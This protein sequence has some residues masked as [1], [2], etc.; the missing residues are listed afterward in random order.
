MTFRIKLL[1]S[2]A[3]SSWREMG[4]DHMVTRSWLRHGAALTIP[5]AL[6][7]CGGG[8]GGV[9]S[10]PAP[11]VATIPTPVPVPAPPPPPPPPTPTAS[12]NDT[13][14]YRATVGAVSMNALAAYNQGATGKGINLA[15]IDSGI[16]LQSA[17]FTGRVSTASQDVAGNASIDDEG[18]HGTAVAFAAAGRRNT[19]GTHGVAFD[20]TLVV[21]RADRSGT[22][23]TEGGSGDDAGCK[24]G[25]DA[26]TRGMD[27]ARIAG[28]RVVNMSLG[29]A[30]MPQSL[31]DA[32]GRATAQGIIVVIAAGNDGS[33]NPD[34]FTAVA[35]TAAARN[36][37]I[38]AGSVGAGDV[39]SSFSDKA[40]TGAAHYLTAVGERVRAPDQ[41][42]TAF[43]W[44]GT[45]FAAP[46][47]SGAIALL[48]QA[49][50][51]L[52]GAQI[53]DLL[54]RTARDAGAA[55]V[56]GT[57]GNG[58]L[59]LTR[60]FQPVGTAMVA[61]SK[62]AVSLGSNA[63]LSAP[64]GD[65]TT[66]PL[67]AVILDS[68]ERAFAIDLATTIR[69]AGPQRLLG[70]ALQGRQRNLAVAS[71]DTTVSLTLAS[72]T[73]G[74][75]AL[76]RSMMSAAQATTAR[77]I[78]GA[79]TQ[80]LGAKTRFG[81]AF[82]QG[83]GTLAA[84]LVGQTQP[85]FLVAGQSG[86]GFEGTAR[87][88]GALRQRVGGIGLTATIESGDVLAQ[89]DAPLAGLSGYRRSGYDRVAL[90]ADRRWAGLAA[91]LVTTLAVSNLRERSTLL[92]ARF[93]GGLGAPR[94]TSWFL[95]A[96][97]RWD[98]GQGWTLGGSWRR[99]WTAA[100]LGRGID[101]G[102]RLTTEAFA[103]DIGKDRL[104]GNDSIGL[105]IAQPLRVAHGGLDY[106]LPTNW[107][108]ATLAVTDWTTQRLNLAPNGRELDV[109]AR[110][111]IALG[112]GDLQ[113]D[114]FWRR[115]PGNIAMLPA[116]IGGAVRYGIAF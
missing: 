85:A 115:D 78:A 28:A 54:F 31:V 64:M 111:R 16:D 23:A 77:A 59:D 66:G 105:R 67:G 93:D 39:I 83:S 45:S 101:G 18:G 7:A 113:T 56:D 89:R 8:G 62:L 99:G 79:V 48:A 35:N 40:G 29:G 103:A 87:S 49:F 75:V 102:G 20:A 33:D 15:I 34:P 41:N 107:D 21:L 92:G 1:E 65:A 68:Y 100:T 91:G 73:N 86:T 95:D 74:D 3:G 9:N 72:R 81:F 80:R 94:A 22:C 25:T 19:S 61:G 70:S 58:V 14:E 116:D 52:S 43:L 5:L 27:A 108:Y 2:D 96:G 37:V 57:Y 104:F 106:R 55:G 12:G 112:R 4:S 114:L 53:V 51:N 63:T 24:F 13:G 46:Q 60:A 97:A 84:Q 76:D 17:E 109:E 98:M 38:V 50:P 6:A 11:P 110:Y 47:I 42:D 32:I 36:L 10:T 90:M 44:S 71:A 82:S 88:A 30:T 69:R 26:I